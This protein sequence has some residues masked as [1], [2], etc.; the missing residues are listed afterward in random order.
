MDIPR[1]ACH[2]LRTEMLV[3]VAFLL[4]VQ[5]K[6]ESVQCWG[7][8]HREQGAS[9]AFAELIDNTGD[10]SQAL[11]QNYPDKCKCLVMC[12]ESTHHGNAAMILTRET[13][14]D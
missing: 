5:S 13:P 11:G 2:T 12:L 8:N 7:A 6:F 1:D 9:Y 4:V 14:L 10:Q 3:A